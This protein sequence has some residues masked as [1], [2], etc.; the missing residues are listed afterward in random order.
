MQG[1]SD[2]AARPATA[3]ADRHRIAPWLSAALLLATAANRAV[4]QRAVAT[5]GRQPHTA[6]PIGTVRQLYDGALPADMVAATFRNGD[7]LFATR[8]VLRGPTVK[9]L[10]RAATPLRTVHFTS[11]GRRYDLEDYFALNRVAGFLVLKDG[12]IAFERYRLGNTDRTRW[13]SMS[14]AKSIT[15]TLIGAAIRDGYIAGLSDPVTTYVPSL[16]ASA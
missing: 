4:A 12:R 5:A 14:V 7:R 2:T 10:P 11:D 3:L 8:R 15:S 9:P 6:E 16:A 1:V 13:M